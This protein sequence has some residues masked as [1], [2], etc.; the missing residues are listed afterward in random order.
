MGTFVHVAAGEGACIATADQTMRIKAAADNSDGA[1]TVI[2]ASIV[3][4]GGPP[5]HVHA[6]ENEAYYVLQGDFEF[7][8]GD[9]TVRGGPGTFVFAPRNVPH[10]YCNVGPAPGRIMFTFTP[11]G[12]EKFFAEAANEPVPERRVAIA[13][14]FGIS[15]LADQQNANPVATS[16]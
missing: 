11:A 9:Q 10:R 4:G 5:L 16:Q 12:I 13:A 7:I 6:I 1:L 14:K 15:M 3:A 2:E 8:C